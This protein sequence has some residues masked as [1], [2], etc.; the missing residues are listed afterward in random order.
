VSGKTTWAR[1]AFA[2]AG[3]KSSP[4]PDGDFYRSLQ[5]THRRKA[6]YCIVYDGVL[7][8]EKMDPERSIAGRLLHQ[9]LKNGA[10]N[11]LWPPFARKHDLEHCPDLT[12]RRV[13]DEILPPSLCRSRRRVI[14]INFDEVADVLE[15]N[16]ELLT[17][18]LKVLVDSK[19]LCYFCILLTS[20]HA[21]DVLKLPRS[22]G[23][24][25]V[26]ISLPLLSVEHMYEVVQ[27]ITRLCFEAVQPAEAGPIATRILPNVQIPPVEP[28]MVHE[29]R[30]FTY[31]LELLAGVPR[32][33]EKALFSL[34]FDS[35]SHAFQPEVFLH[36]LELVEDSH[37]VFNQLLRG[38]VRFITLKYNR[39]LGYLNTLEI[40]P[41]LISCSL[42]GACFYRSEKISFESNERGVEGGHHN[43]G[44]L[45]DDGV[46]FLTEPPAGQSGMPSLPVAPPAPADWSE[47]SS[48]LRPWRTSRKARDNQAFCIVIPFIWMH[49]VVARAAL[50]ATPL[51]PPLP[52]IQL[53]SQLGSSL[54]PSEKERLSLSVLALRMYFLAECD[55]AGNG[56]EMCFGV[57]DLFPVPLQRTISPSHVCLPAAFSWR[58]AQSTEEIVAAAFKPARQQSKRQRQDDDSQQHSLSS[59]VQVFYQNKE[60][61]EA[62][63]SFVLSR[64][65]I[66]LQDKQSH[67]FK[68]AVQAGEPGGTVSV[69]IIRQEHDKFK[70][71]CEHLFVFI[72]D[73]RV[74]EKAQSGLKD[75]ELAID[76]TNE[77]GF[78]G[79]L[80]KRLKLHHDRDEDVLQADPTDS[81][82]LWRL[83]SSASSTAAAAATA[84]SASSAVDA[85]SSSPCKKQRASAPLRRSNGSTHHR[86]QARQR[87]GR[88]QR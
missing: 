80:L 83:S 88:R 70:A 4:L 27:H 32:F 49:L 58:V 13:V 82:Q 41:L 38:V 21:L 30:H 61:A 35:S 14:V 53:L 45:E 19:A 11:K 3:S 79:P 2:N 17:E 84:A 85:T 36:N 18:V 8:W 57:R 9:H 76:D 65:V 34:G 1:Y 5:D 87:A 24:G 10:E 47:G 60:K 77:E 20:T 73:K 42:F 64:P 37:F 68:H 63:D 59:A 44:A 29:L 71:A 25:H 62:P 22:S 43:I 26:A 28:Q 56:E 66:A 6:M 23:F 12:L 52:Q 78:Y 51:S 31:L 69:T 46:I 33:L 67:A 74:V 81:L 75:N 40:F 48:L 50:Y 72:T 39:F 55:Q 15:N 7:P 86:Q 16:K 54:T